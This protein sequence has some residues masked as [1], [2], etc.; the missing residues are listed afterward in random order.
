MAVAIDSAYGTLVKEM[1]KDII[2][3]NIVNCEGQVFHT[4]SQNKPFSYIVKGNSIALQNTNH[5]IPRSHI[6]SAL[7]IPNPTAS[8]LNHLRG[9]S[10]ILALITDSRITG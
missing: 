4:T 1:N 5:N 3:N 7:N 6:E 2:W 8:K 10:Y 9:P